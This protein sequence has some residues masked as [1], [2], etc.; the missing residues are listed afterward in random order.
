MTVN[1]LTAVERHALEQSPLGDLYA[2]KE[3]MR[4][5]VVDNFPSLGKLAAMRFIEWVQHNPAVSYLCPLV[6]LPSTLFAG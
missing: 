4:T 3:K 5:I 2:P 1:T 6:K